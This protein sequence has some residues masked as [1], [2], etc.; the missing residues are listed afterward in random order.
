M[1]ECEKLG[2]CPIFRDELAYL[3]QT[4][5]MLKQDYCL[6]DPKRCAR[7]LVAIEGVPVPADLFPNHRDRVANILGKFKTKITPR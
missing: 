2:K 7:Y 5:A 6:R 1:A 3:P 4:A